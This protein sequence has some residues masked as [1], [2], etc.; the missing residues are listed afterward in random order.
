MLYADTNHVA[1][2][3]SFI[4]VALIGIVADDRFVRMNH[5]QTPCPAEEHRTNGEAYSPAKGRK[6]IPDARPVVAIVDIHAPLAFH[7]GPADIGFSAQNPVGSELIIIANGASEK[8]AARIVLRPAICI[9][10]YFLVEFGRLPA[11]KYLLVNIPRQSRV[12]ALEAAD[13][14]ADAAPN[15]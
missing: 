12:E 13:G 10:C 7:A 14:S 5:R 11:T 1:G 8:D 15:S 3:P 9:L 4:E 2:L 6:A